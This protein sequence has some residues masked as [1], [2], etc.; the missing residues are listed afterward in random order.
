MNRTPLLLLLGAAAVAALVRCGGSYSPTQPVPSPTATP[1]PVAT[2]T[3]GVVLPPGMTCNPTPPPLYGIKVK[4][5]DDS[6]TRKVLDSK[7]LVMNIDAYCA[8]AGTGGETQ[9]FCDTRQ[10][11][12]PERVACDF[13]ATG[14]A[15]NGRWGPT[16]LWNG[17]ACDGENFASCANHQQNQ[18][19][20]IAKT[21]GHY[22]ACAAPDRPVHPEGQACGFEDVTIP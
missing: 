22:E 15:P 4:I 9:K 5:H 20:A 7:P 12:H 14:I 21:S 1:T 11:G 19:M 8:R 17:L 3:P 10:E 6:P 16:W 13:L 18:F 2:P